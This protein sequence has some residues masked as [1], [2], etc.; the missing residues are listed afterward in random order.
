VALAHGSSPSAVGGD[1]LTAHTGDELY[2]FLMCPGPIFTH[3]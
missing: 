2:G 3:D 1:E